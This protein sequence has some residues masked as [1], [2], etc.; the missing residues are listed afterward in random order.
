MHFWVIEECVINESVFVWSRNASLVMN[1]EAV[2]ER[3]VKYE[4]VTLKHE[5][6]SMLRGTQSHPL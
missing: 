6:V 2:G 4:D 5:L 3:T 1:V